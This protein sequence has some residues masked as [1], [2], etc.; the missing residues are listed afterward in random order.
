[1]DTNPA[2]VFAGL[3]EV[4]IEHAKRPDAGPGELLIRTHKS[5]ISTGT[6]LTLLSGEYPPGSVWA[7]HAR[8]PMGAGY[9]NVGEVIGVGDG[10]GE[11]WLGRRVATHGGHA[12]YVTAAPG[13]ARPV[14]DGVADE[15]AVFFAISEI[16]MNAVRRSQLAWGEAVV[17]YGAGLLGQLT[18]RYCRLC[19]ARPVVVVDVAESRLGRLPPD[20]PS[21]VPANSGRCDAADTV[22]QA[23][24]GRKA[25][26]AFEVTGAAD[27]IPEQLRA[28]RDQGRLVILGCP[29]G[30]TQF[31]FHDL[32][33]SPSYTI[34]GA[35]NRSTPQYETPDN[36]W[37]WQ[38]HAELFFELLADGE[39]SV[40]PL[41]SHCEPYT[42][43]PALYELLLADRSQAMGVILDWS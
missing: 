19:G 24:R 39:V 26:V 33:N 3:R 7:G 36:P 1:M 32:C 13:S 11:A 6:E 18:A 8:F 4:V 23:T 38:R 41:I 27:L 25:D 30:P 17:V 15:H 31:D 40:E 42:N 12:R 34:I 35:H 5:L 16:V 22:A 29:R 28:L 10:V 2:V 43:A 20:D 9:S 37:T 21:I 14:R